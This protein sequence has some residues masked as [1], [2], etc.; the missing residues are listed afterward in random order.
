MHDHLQHSYSYQQLQGKVVNL[1]LLLLA[2]LF[3][4]AMQT[5]LITIHGLGTT[6]YLQVV[7]D[8]GAFP[9]AVSLELFVDGSFV[10]NVEV[11]AD[12]DDGSMLLLIPASR[13]LC[14][15]CR[16]PDY[17][18]L[19]AKANRPESQLMACASV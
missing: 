9:G 7:I 15:V 13:L 11:S 17:W 4:L 2:D 12:A 14:A 5:L 18:L 10:T 1:A 19:A 6:W 16:L 8:R 3:N